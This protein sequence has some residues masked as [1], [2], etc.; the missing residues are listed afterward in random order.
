MF[1][2]FAIALWLAASTTAATAAQA[3]QGIEVIHLAPAS[4]RIAAPDAPA[5]PLAPH[6]VVPVEYT[7]SSELPEP[8]VFLMMLVG[9]LL[10]GV[11][12]GHISHEKFEQ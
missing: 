1:S 8:E 11:R 10:I 5:A 2:K 12:A 6:V 9:L 7:V 4:A 3:T